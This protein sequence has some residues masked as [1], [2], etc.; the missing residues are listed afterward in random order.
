M[1]DDLR[2]VGRVL[3]EAHSLLVSEQTRL[4]EQY[5]STRSDDS[6]AGGPQQTMQGIH[7]LAG[8]V[9]DALKRI[10]LA[11]GF[12]ALGL[13][14]RAER[15]MVTARM[16]PVSL[17]AGAER[18]ARPLGEDTVRALEMIRDLGFFPAEVAVEIDV[19]LAAPEATY[20]PAD[21]AAY[22]RDRASR[23]G[24]C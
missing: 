13:D 23:A 22:D 8:S 14:V 11:V 2:H 9:G 7:A 15:A 24:Q 21:W 12:K 5:G 4:K 3:D 16:R 1:S 6:V 20:P 18:M 17:P 10:S 19:V